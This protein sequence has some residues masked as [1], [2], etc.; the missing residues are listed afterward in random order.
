MNNLQSFPQPFRRSSPQSSPQS[1]RKHLSRLDRRAVAGLGKIAA[2]IACLG[3]LAGCMPNTPSAAAG[4]ETRYPYIVESQLVTQPVV[5]QADAIQLDRVETG[6]V[7]AFLN[8]F[9]KTGGGVLEIRAASAADDPVVKARVQALRQHA[10]MRGAQPHELRLRRVAAPNGSDSGSGPIILSFESSTAKVAACTQRNAPTAHNPSNMTHPDLGCSLRRNI[11]AM[12][13]NPSDLK[14]PQTEQQGDSMRRS[15]VI[16]NYRAGE[17][18]E[19]TRGS[20]ES[21]G[22]IRGLGQ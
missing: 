14:E 1:S 17:P 16:R 15:R 5:Y 8:Q 21:A 11:A 6:R 19:A 10:L 4:P 18:T 9:F 13:S 3:W 20:K 7:A 12:I 2:A 22:S